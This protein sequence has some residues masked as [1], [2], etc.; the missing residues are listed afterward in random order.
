MEEILMNDK[1]S[2]KI[3]MKKEERSK[4]FFNYIT[5]SNIVENYKNLLILSAN[6][7]FFYEYNEMKDV[8]IILN[9]RKLNN[10][11]HLNDFM[12]AL[13]ANLQKDTYFYGCFIDNK[14]S[15]RNKGNKKNNL[16]RFFNS[17]SIITN[18]P[19]LTRLLS[20]KNVYNL[21]ESHSFQI[22]DMKEIN[23]VIYFSAQKL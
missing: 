17:F 18:Y 3:L 14:F 21:F 4:D 19:R 6:H 10:I 7:H 1:I 23:D 5:K 20:I 13:L 12:S 8:K 22:L 16:T 2:V 9:I 11:Y 15:F